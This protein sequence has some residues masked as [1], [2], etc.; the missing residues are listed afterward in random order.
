M[1]SPGPF[2]RFSQ[3]HCFNSWDNMPY[4]HIVGYVYINIIYPITGHQY[5]S[6]SFVI[7]F[8]GTPTKKKKRWPGDPLR[9]TGPRCWES[10]RWQRP[11]LWKFWHRSSPSR[12]P[13]DSH[14]SIRLIHVSMDWFS[15]ENLHRKPSMFPFNIGLSC[16]FS[17]KAI[18]WMLVTVGTYTPYID[19]GFHSHGGSQ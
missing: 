11:P 3:F 12:I 16:K 8:V 17:L 14:G 18:H 9:Y 19:G 4:P 10:L 5:K 1:H 2:L 6:T 15:W 7:A 13:V